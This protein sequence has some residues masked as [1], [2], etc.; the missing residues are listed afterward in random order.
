MNGAYSP[1][2]ITFI[3]NAVLA[4]ALA[5]VAW[6]RRGAPDVRW[7]GAL[8]AGAAAPVV[9]HAAHL[10]GLNR[11]PGLDVT[12]IGFGLAG[13][14]YARI[15]FSFRL[16]DLA[17]RQQAE[18]QRQSKERR[19][20]LD[21]LPVGVYR[22]TPE[23]QFVDANPALADMLGY[24]DRESLLTANVSEFYADIEQRARWQAMVER[25]G[26]AYNFEGQL[27]RRDGRLIWARGSAR[28]S[29]DEAGQVL[30]YEGVLE[31]ITERKRAAEAA[32]Q[33][34]RLATLNAVGMA[35]VSSLEA[36]AVLHQILRLTCR[37]LGADAGSILLK[38]PPGEELVFVITLAGDVKALHGQHL[39]VGQGIAG[40]VAQRGQAVRVD[41]ARQDERWRGEMD[42]V[43]NLQTRS[44]LCA[45]LKQRGQVAGVIE[46]ISEREARF[47]WED[48]SLLEAIA[49]IAAMA[50]QNTQLYAATRSYADRMV[51]VNQVGQALTAALDLPSV[52]RAALNLIQRLFAAQNVSLF[53][54]DPHT[55]DVQSVQT[56][57]GL[58]PTAIP[59]AWGRE[60]GLAGWALAHNT[61]VLVEDAQADPRFSDRL[62]RYLGVRTRALMAVPLYTPEGAVGVIQVGSDQPGLYTHEEL[63]TLQAMASTLA[64]ALQ[65]VRLHEE[66]KALL[67]ER[68]KAEPA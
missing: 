50:L 32:R 9:F 36:D 61:P 15:L 46:V 19:D 28:V 35:A 38:H 22:T 53:M 14:I 10:A 6:R 64:A 2:T 67:R 33:A 31:D 34:D 44:V 55:G 27:R 45:P 57:A 26:I 24:P 49:A 4:A 60:E 59:V 7:L 16:D 29:R 43:T 5:R 13:F 51:R 68:E 47:S 39:P 63:N 30:C 8:L 40:W 56:L 18:A 20:L 23:G 54:T 48:L 41:D 1:Y 37:A 17:R 42:A 65:N 62:D 3:A 12:P 58:E 25:K 66:L 21:S 11:I 52:T